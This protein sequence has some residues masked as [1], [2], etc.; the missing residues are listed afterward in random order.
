[1]RQIALLASLAAL[2]AACSPVPAPPPPPGP[3]FYKAAQQQGQG[4]DSPTTNATGVTTVKVIDSSSGGPGAG[5]S[6]TA[7]AVTTV[8]VVGPPAVDTA[9]ADVTMKLTIKDP[10][11]AAA[12]AAHAASEPKVG[13]FKAQATPALAAEE[14]R[15][16]A[17]EAARAQPPVR[18]PK[19]VKLEVQ[20][21]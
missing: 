14:S 5:S 21:P 3:D 13:A 9:S 7:A 4:H 10:A 8:A 18:E 17:L 20:S 6:T 15:R 11:L 2:A 16:R 12:L 19:R 1:M